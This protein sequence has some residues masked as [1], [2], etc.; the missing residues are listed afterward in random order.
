MILY[1]IYSLLLSAFAQDFNPKELEAVRL[2]D[3]FK[4][5][6]TQPIL[7]RFNC[8]KAQSSNLNYKLI[9][10]SVLSDR[11]KSAAQFQDGSKNISLI[12]G[13]STLDFVVLKIERMKVFIK[14]ST[15]SQCEAF[16][17]PLEN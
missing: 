2:A 6:K 13:E 7:N 3:P 5:K 12:E 10:T 9:S 14:N 15:S 17:V 1:L 8:Q 4:T 11:S 16:E